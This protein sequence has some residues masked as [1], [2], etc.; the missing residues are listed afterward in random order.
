MLLTLSAVVAVHS[1][2]MESTDITGCRDDD[3]TYSWSLSSVK[4]YMKPNEEYHELYGSDDCTVGKGIVPKTGL[5]CVQGLIN[6][7][8][9]ISDIVNT[10]DLPVIGAITSRVETIQSTPYRTIKTESMYVEN[11]SE[12]EQEGH[13]SQVTMQMTQGSE[14]SMGK[15]VG[16]KASASFGIPLIGETKIEVSGELNLGEK[17][18]STT[19]KSIIFTSQKV[20]VP[21]KSRIRLFYEVNLAKFETKYLGNFTLDPDD[22]IIRYCLNKFVLGKWTMNLEKPG[23]VNEVTAIFTA[24]QQTLN[25]LPMLYVSDGF[26]NRIIVMKA[27]PLTTFINDPLIPVVDV[28]NLS[29]FNIFNS[30]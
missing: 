15:K 11:H 6:Y 2:I 18:T 5:E 28:L 3:A 24:T 1:F 23:M 13:T 30:N 29:S 27:E 20:K 14:F 9:G 25:N 19:S 26:E 8:G 22:K 16:I 7:C 12:V 17:R 10:P 21:P 4:C